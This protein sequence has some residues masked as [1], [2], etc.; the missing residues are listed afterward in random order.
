VVLVLANLAA[1]ALRFVLFRSWVFPHAARA[2]SSADAASTAVQ[3]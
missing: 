3:R 2:I 1:T